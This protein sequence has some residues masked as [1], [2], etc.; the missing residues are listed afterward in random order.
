MATP[1]YSKVSTEEQVLP[2]LK[3]SDS[4]IERARNAPLPYFIRVREGAK[5]VTKRYLSGAERA[6]RKKNNPDE[7]KSIY[8]V[9]YRVMGT[10]RNVLT[11]LQMIG[12]SETMD[13]LMNKAITRDNY[14]TTMRSQFDLEQKPKVVKSV[15]TQKLHA[16][17][18]PADIIWFSN[19]L[20]EV[21]YVNTSGGKKD[22]MPTAQSSSASQAFIDKYNRIPK[23]KHLDI[24]TMDIATGKNTRLSGLPK[25][26]SDK[27]KVK[28]QKIVTNSVDKLIGAFT[29]IYGSDLGR[30]QKTIDSVRN[31]LAEKSSNP[32]TTKK[33]TRSIKSPSSQSISSP[34]TKSTS[35][36]SSP[37]PLQNK[38]PGVGSS[39]VNLGTK[40]PPKSILKPPTSNPPPSISSSSS[41]S[42]RT[43]T[44]SPLKSVNPVPQISSPRMRIAGASAGGVPRYPT[45]NKI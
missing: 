19:N 7:N 15:E 45:F 32:T 20:K 3:I 35:R 1:S 24:S 10:P 21:K 26:K 39:I 23:G 6:W 16:K 8:V 5:Q 42:S 43:G 13:S 25:P 31:A 38:S 27:V 12:K 14:Q 22:L 18:E 37:N 29:L 44:T 30:Y 17:W 36:S 9:E 2:G 28:G 11:A 34:P 41:S 4:L 33:S 40:S